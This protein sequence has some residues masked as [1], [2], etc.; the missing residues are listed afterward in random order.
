MTLEELQDLCIHDQ[1]DYAEINNPETDEEGIVVTWTDD[2]NVVCDENDE[3]I[4]EEDG[5]KKRD[6]VFFNK[7]M[8]AGFNIEQVKKAAVRGRDVHQITRIVGYYSRVNNF[9]KSKRGELND[10]H[11]GNYSIG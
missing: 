5:S 6:M 10:R 3:P 4:I 9:N 11:G 8:M 7:D 1:F 2:R